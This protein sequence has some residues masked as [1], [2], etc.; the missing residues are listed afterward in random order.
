M[1]TFTVK[2]FYGNTNKVDIY[3]RTGV[4][5][6]DIVNAVIALQKGIQTRPGYRW[7]DTAAIPEKTFSK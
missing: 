3:E 1:T 4:Q 5:E 7:I 2:V 6:K